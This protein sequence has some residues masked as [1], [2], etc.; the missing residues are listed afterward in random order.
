M[1]LLVG[2]YQLVLKKYLDAIGFT[3]SIIVAN[4]PEGLIL[5]VTVCL[6][7][8]AKTMN[9]KKCRVKDL[10]CVETLGSVSCICSDKTGTLTQNI[11]TVSNMFFDFEIHT[12]IIILSL[13]FFDLGKRRI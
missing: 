10:K 8:A 6:S 3:V 2:I 5:T 11:M 13:Y 7:M 4:V 1:G 9:K 12:V